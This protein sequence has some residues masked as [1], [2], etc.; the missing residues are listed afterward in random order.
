MA[1]KSSY[2]NWETL[3]LNE[4]TPEFIKMLGLYMYPDENGNM[5]ERLAR[6]FRLLNRIGINNPLTVFIT[7]P[8]P[9]K[10]RDISALHR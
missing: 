10:H 4:A 7:P 2:R 1:N 5:N 6:S 9:Q 3:Y 8:E